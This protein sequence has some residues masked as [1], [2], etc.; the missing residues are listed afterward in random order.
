M[1]SD[2]DFKLAT[3]KIAK[4]EAGHWLAAYKLGWRPREIE[5]TAPESARGHYGYA[6]TTY[7]VQLITIDDVRD[8]ARGRVKILYSGAYAENYDGKDFD[9]K[10]IQNDMGRG[11]GAYSDFFKAEE[12][13]FFYYNCLENKKDWEA[14]FSPIIC[15]VQFM[16]EMHYAFIDKVG[17]LAEEKVNIAGDRV[18]F[19]P[20]ELEAIF[21]QSEIRLPDFS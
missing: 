13:Y 20:E 5:I 17:R 12:I 2:Y 9:R 18:N 19:S 11:G 16:I 3:Y 14:E 8:Y 15:D 7:G 21:L 4:H 1:E 10:Q 6:Q